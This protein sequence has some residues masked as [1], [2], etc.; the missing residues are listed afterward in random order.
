[1]AD[2]QVIGYRVFAVAGV[3]G[4]GDQA[5]RVQ[6]S[7]PSSCKVALISSTCLMYPTMCSQ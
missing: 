5:G 3:A 2:Y 7:R 6:Y 4:Y 1:V